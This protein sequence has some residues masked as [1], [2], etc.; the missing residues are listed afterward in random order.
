MCALSFKFRRRD[1]TERELYICVY[2][3]SMLA[4]K[5]VHEGFLIIDVAC[6]YLAPGS[7]CNAVD[8][9]WLGCVSANWLTSG[10]DLVAE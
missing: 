3:C 7:L 6:S 1:W 8:F 2:R 9:G 4:N 10:A 5:A